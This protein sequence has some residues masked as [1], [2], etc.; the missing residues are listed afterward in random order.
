MPAKSEAQSTKSLVIVESPTKAKTITKFLGKDFTV[1]ASMGHIRDLPESA[2][3]IPAKYKK[4]PWSRLGV[5]TEADFEPLYVIPKSKKEQV[6]ELQELVKKADRLF[7]ATDEDREGE[8]ISWH[9]YQVLKPRIPTRRLVFNEIT[10]EAIQHAIENPRDIDEALVRAQETRRIVDRLFGY[11][12]SPL[13]WKKMAPGFSAGRVQSV[14]VRLLVERERARIRFR[15]ARYWGV[16]ATFRKPDAEPAFEA[17]L[18]Q[19]GGK[20]VATSKDFNP[21]TGMLQ[22]PESVVLLGEAEAQRVVGLLQTA[23]ILTRSVEEKPFVQR[24]AAPFVTSTL[25]MEANSKLRFSAK[26]TMQIAQQLYENGFITYMRTDSTSLSDEAIRGARALIVREY[27]EEYLSPAVRQYET[28]VKNAQEAHEAIRPASENFA[29]PETVRTQLGE[30]AFRLYDLIYKR[31]VA[32]QM[33]DARG[34]NTVVTI[35]AGDATFRASGKT[36]E[37]AGF[38]KAYQVSEDEE[39]EEKDR[40]LPRLAPGDSLRCEKAETL[41]RKTQPPN[42]YTEGSLIRELERLGIGRPSTWASIVELVLNRSYA[43]KKGN[44]LVPTFTAMAV[45]G[46]LEQYFT[47]YLDYSYTARLEDD[48]DAISRGESDPLTYLRNFY[49]GEND[50]GLRALVAMGER[51]IDPRVIN[52]IPLGEW[53]G[54]KLEVRIGKYGP[55]LS[56][57]E[58]RASLPEDL[59]PD[60]L[61]LEKAV[62]LLENASREPE[63][64]GLHPETGEPVYLKVGRYG[65]YVQLGDGRDGSKPKMAS[66]LAGTDLKDVDLNYAVKLLSLPR[67]LGQ[68]PETGEAVI[69]AN[70]RFGPYIQCGEETRSLPPEE[71]PLDITLERALEILAQPRTTRRRAAARTQTVLKEFGPHP[72]F[73]KPVKLLSGRYGPYVTDGEIHASVPRGQDPMQIT[74]EQAYQMLVERKQQLEEQGGTTKRA[75]RKAARSRAKA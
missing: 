66:L 23:P 42:R 75:S 44:A 62:E 12:V 35:E 73:G 22:D 15:P 67:T 47:H 38:L 31:T 60:E 25:Q 24:P 3:E 40:H 27:G 33:A 16:K 5:N 46:L 29:D 18:V 34:T 17:D 72:V 32:C 1:R 45:I 26:R 70:G 36:I 9:L 54:R 52:S 55:F 68:H 11:E 14:A 74:E 51:E 4:E 28:K 65:P 56:D 59:P 6:K 64:L 30:D 37:F 19:L 20:K 8:S 50:R 13:L 63:S 43:F 69:A 53:Q 2:S 39:G 58:R 48:L 7:L 10:R 21:D 41:D 71:S 61:T 57:G 49:Y